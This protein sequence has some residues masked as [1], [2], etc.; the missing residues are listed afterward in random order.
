MI[1]VDVC[2]LEHGKGD[3]VI[4]LTKGLNL[5]VVLG[6]LVTELVAGKAKDYKAVFVVGSDLLVELLEAL[7]LG[8]EAAFRGGVDD[9]D[10]FAF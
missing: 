7:E 5:G 1:A 10:G 3:A 9:E 2:L 8:S 4:E 6:I